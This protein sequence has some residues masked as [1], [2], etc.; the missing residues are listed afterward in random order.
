MSSST[1][2]FTTDDGFSMSAYLATPEGTPRGGI[3][4]VQEI[5]G[6]NIHIREV[7]D[8]FAADGYTAIAPALFDRLER[9]VE[10]GYTQEDMT[11]GVDLARKRTDFDRAVKDVADAANHVRTSLPAGAKVGCTGYCWGGVVTAASAIRSAGAL[12]CAVS[13]YGS[14]TVNL[15]GSPLAMP[16]LCHYGELDGSIPQADIDTLQAAW[17]TAEVH[18]YTGA[19][20]GFNCNHRAQYG[21]EAATLARARTMAFF[22]AHLG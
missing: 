8:G 11:A 12:D 22:A 3:V 15:V 16:L 10:L 4:V 19:N 9:G 18:V 6:V 1:I 21:E 17:P 14:G 7:C 5:F 13:Y 2:S 20:H